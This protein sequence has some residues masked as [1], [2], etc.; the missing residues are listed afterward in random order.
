MF[1]R[2]ILTAFASVILVVFAAFA[3]CTPS[4]DPPLASFES[5]VDGGGPQECE[6]SGGVWV[7][8]IG[9]FTEAC[10]ASCAAA[11]STC[12]SVPQ[13]GSPGTKCCCVGSCPDQADE[14]AACVNTG[15][16]Y[17]AGGLCLGVIIIGDPIPL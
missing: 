10:E 3:A 16:S 8:G 11:G 15:G 1:T 12:G 7:E 6:D 14:C 9:C 5:A 4:S 13:L 2:P 17:S